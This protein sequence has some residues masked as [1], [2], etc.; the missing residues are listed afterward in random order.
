MLSV[1]IVGVKCEVYYVFIL[2]WV[3]I[4]D[5]RLFQ[6]TD[7][8]YSIQVC[9]LSFDLIVDNYINFQVMSIDVSMFGM[10]NLV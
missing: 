6:A 5:R 2:F 8:S 9:V 7:N 1:Q 3:L 10:M 4:C